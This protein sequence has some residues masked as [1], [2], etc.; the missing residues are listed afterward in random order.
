VVNRGLN[1]QQSGRILVGAV[2]NEWRCTVTTILVENPSVQANEEWLKF[3]ADAP[4]GQGRDVV[5]V[6]GYVTFV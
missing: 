1:W 6:S 2:S 5:V 4:A 3:R